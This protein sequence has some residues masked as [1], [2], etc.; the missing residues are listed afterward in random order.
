M[1]CQ[2]G[3]FLPSGMMDA[4]TGDLALLPHP[5]SFHLT[6]SLRDLYNHQQLYIRHI[7][8]STTCPYGKELIYMQHKQ[9]TLGYYFLFVENFF[10]V[11]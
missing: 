9:P 2:I 6:F 5:P 8:S 10:Q 7:S 3:N 11:L 1:V 4:C